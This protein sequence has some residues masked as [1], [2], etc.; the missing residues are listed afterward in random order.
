MAGQTESENLGYLDPRNPLL[1]YGNS[2]FDIRHRV[3]FSAVWT[4]PFFKGRRH[5]GSNRPGDG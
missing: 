1:D 3:A 5:L 4:E 2:D